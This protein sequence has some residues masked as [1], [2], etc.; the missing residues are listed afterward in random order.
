MLKIFW[1]CYLFSPTIWA[2]EVVQAGKGDRLGTT[3]SGKGDRLGSNDYSALREM[4]RPAKPQCSRSLNTSIKNADDV[5][6]SLSLQYKGEYIWN[7]SLQL[8]EL[9]GYDYRP[10]TMTCKTFM[11]SSFN[12]LIQ[13]EDEKSTSC[14][15]TQVTEETGWEDVIVKGKYQTK[16]PG[17][18]P[19]TSLEE[20]RT[21]IRQS[22]VFQLEIGMMTLER[23]RVDFLKQTEMNIRPALEYYR[24]SNQ[25]TNEIYADKIIR[26]ANC[27]NN[28]GFNFTEKCLKC[29]TEEGYEDCKKGIW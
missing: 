24:G 8:A 5:W 15:L 13:P 16:I 3:Q 4:F 26:C 25:E 29:T 12:P 19:I 11:E 14:G 18:K 23:K 17:Q 9:H 20:Y 7:V 21:R 2:E 6:N 27:M 10:G 1:I 28:N 22:M